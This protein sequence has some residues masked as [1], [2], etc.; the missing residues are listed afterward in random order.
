MNLRN[1]APL[2]L[3]WQKAHWSR[4]HYKK[5][6]DTFGGLLCASMQPRRPGGVGFLEREDVAVRSTNDEA[7]VGKFC[8]VSKGYYKD[9]FVDAFLNHA[10]VWLGSCLALFCFC[11][12]AWLH[13]SC[14]CGLTA[15]RRCSSIRR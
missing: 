15:M 5:V 1:R 8:A 7:T 4:Q 12:T 13:F 2:Q 10:P 11:W 9:G 14:A 6:N 3:D